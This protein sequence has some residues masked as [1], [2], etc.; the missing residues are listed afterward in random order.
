MVSFPGTPFLKKETGVTVT[1]MSEKPRQGPVFPI[2]TDHL[3]MC[4][5]VWK[6]SLFCTNVIQGK[7]IPHIP[8]APPA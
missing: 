3:Q 8:A 6:I 4:G 5:D 7:I 2:G 1:Y